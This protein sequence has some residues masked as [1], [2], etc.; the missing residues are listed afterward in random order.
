MVEIRKPR[1]GSK[2]LA[3]ACRGKVGDVNQTLLHYD[4]D[5]SNQRATSPSCYVRR[6]CSNRVAQN[7]MMTPPRSAALP[8]SY[9]LECPRR[10]SVAICS[11]NVKVRQR[12]V[13]EGRL[14]CLTE[15]TKKDSVA[16]GVPMLGLWYI[17]VIPSRPEFY[18]GRNRPPQ[19]Q[20][21]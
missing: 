16:N 17:S 5:D 12:T 19:G 10:C 3:G 2:N 4:F 13:R 9:R 7:L 1:S 8:L 11:G 20:H 15:A 14:K 21:L 6:R 18:E